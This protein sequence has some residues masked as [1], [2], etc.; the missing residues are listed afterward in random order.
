ML[1]V[2]WE[3]KHEEG[4]GKIGLRSLI[5]HVSLLFPNFVTLDKLLESKFTP[6][7]I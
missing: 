4:S 6:F 2:V 3:G 7:L 5:P 1:T